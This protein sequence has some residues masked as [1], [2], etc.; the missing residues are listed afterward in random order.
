MS[1]CLVLGPLAAVL[2]AG[3]TEAADERLRLVVVEPPDVAVQI[4]GAGEHLAALLAHLCK[5]KLK[6]MSVV[7]FTTQP[8]R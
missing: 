4:A 7:R 2:E 3:G 1:P 5:E 8:K 6:F